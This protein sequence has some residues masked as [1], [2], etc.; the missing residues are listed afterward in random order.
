[1]FCLHL[2]GFEEAECVWVCGCLDV[3]VSQVAGCGCR[4]PVSLS[5][6]Y[7]GGWGGHLAV[8]LRCSAADSSWRL[9]AQLQWVLLPPC[10]VTRCVCT[11]QHV[12][13]ARSTLTLCSVCFTSISDSFYSSV[14]LLRSKLPK[15][16]NS[17]SSR[18]VILVKST[19]QPSISWCKTSFA[20]SKNPLHKTV[21]RGDGGSLHDLPS[22]AL[23]DD[24]WFVFL[25]YWPVCARVTT[26][27]PFLDVA[28]VYSDEGVLK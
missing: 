2:K 11:A 4:S 10:D 19:K 14:L 20:H 7:S 23:S 9:G 3:W 17:H 16:M 21:T 22:V 6:Q 12:A 13:C 5:L 25:Y 15:D 28:A 1:M 26:A 27:P 24:K 18:M 8:A